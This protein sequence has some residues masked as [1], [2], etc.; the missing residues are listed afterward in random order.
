MR[1]FRLLPALVLVLALP[2]TEAAAQT[3]DS[4]TAAVGEREG[5]AA[6]HGESVAGARWSSAAATFF[7]TP[8]LGGVAVLAQSGRDP[9]NAPSFVP[10]PPAPLVSSPSYERAYREAYRQEYLA[11]RRHAMRSSMIV[12]SVLFFAAAAALSG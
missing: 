11:R 5:A 12:T 7:L 6:G 10:P 3:A 4:A 9:E 8:F 1:A 2:G